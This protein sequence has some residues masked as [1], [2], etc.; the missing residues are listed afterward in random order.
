[1]AEFLAII[2]PLI[3][4]W[5]TLIGLTLLVNSHGNVLYIILGIVLIPI[6]L[7][8]EKCAFDYSNKENKQKEEERE[9]WRIEARQRAEEQRKEEIERLRTYPVRGLSPLEFE[10]FTAQYL[11]EHGYKKVKLTPKTG[12]Y[13][14]DIL[15]IDPTGKK[16]CV[17][18]KKYSNPVGISAVQEIH[19]AK[20]HYKCDLAYIATTSQG[21]T[22]SAIQLA[23][24][25]GVNLY[26][27]NDYSRQFTALN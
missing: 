27:F 5:P 18:C 19:G 16:V 22:K 21:Y 14:A 26:A 3:A 10:A 13:G 8:T 1:M 20:S 2:L 25:V 23:K 15:A 4:W 17:Q 11:K 12:D 7:Y 24:D 6:G 9:K